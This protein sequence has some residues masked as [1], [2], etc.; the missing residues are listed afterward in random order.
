[1]LENFQYHDP[2]D[3]GLPLYSA[4]PI[5]ELTGRLVVFSPRRLLNKGRL[6]TVQWW[7]CAEGI[8][9]AFTQGFYRD[10]DPM[11]IFLND[12]EHGGKTFRSVTVGEG[13]HRIAIACIEDF[14][15]YARVLG[16][17]NRHMRRYAF[18]KMVREVSG[19]YQ[20]LG[21]V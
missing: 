21:Y 4:L 11:E 15:I 18:S 17:V 20:N 6:Y 2:K 3:L 12:E 9:A 14:D 8:S 1:M 10:E 13:N 16:G 5:S 7:A 19:L